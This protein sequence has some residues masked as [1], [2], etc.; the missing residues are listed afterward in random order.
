MCIQ[1]SPEWALEF[2]SKLGER[3][4]IYVHDLR[5]A[6]YIYVKVVFNPLVR[7]AC[8]RLASR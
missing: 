7:A 4:G 1:S 5:I 3:F 6:H 2:F 8:S